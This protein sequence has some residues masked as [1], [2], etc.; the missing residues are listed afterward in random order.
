MAI[1]N[2]SIKSRG[3]SRLGYFHWRTHIVNYIDKNWEYIFGPGVRKKKTLVGTI[4]GCL[5]HNSPAIFTSGQEIFKEAGWWK[6]S[7][8][9]K[10]SFFQKLLQQDKK[11]GKKVE[12]DFP[13]PDS[14]PITSPRTIMSPKHNFIDFFKEV[15]SGNQCSRTLPYI[16]KKSSPPAS[17]KN[18]DNIEVDNL[19]T[20]QSSL[21]D[22]LAEN[23]STDGMIFNDVMPA[24]DTPFDIK[25]PPP[26]NSKHLN[27]ESSCE[28][29]QPRIVQV[30]NFQKIDDGSGAV[31]IEQLSNVDFKAM[32]NISEVTETNEIEEPCKKSLFTK[33]TKRSYPWLN[34]DEESD[35][36][37]CA[38]MV[39]MNEHQEDDLYHRL[40]RIIDLEETLKITIPPKIR[41]LYRKLQLR[42]FKRSRGKAIFDV[43]KLNSNNISEMKTVGQSSLLDRYQLLSSSS[44]QPRS[45]NARIVGSSKFEC[46]ESPFTGRVLHPFIYRSTKHFPPWLKVI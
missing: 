27:E 22:F 19:N 6:L 35:H 10:P 37:E 12:D 5:S 2:L 1:Y 30:T 44:S 38:N 32:E 24:F 8:N 11:P 40:K 28:T 34:E 39:Q 29:F 23:L 43:D 36:E 14:S 25:S 20:V 33:T 21:M 18:A 15:D 46:F 3:L 13:V 17:P 45:F 42:N 41:R 26:S 4:A 7:Q 16:A 9:E 31:G